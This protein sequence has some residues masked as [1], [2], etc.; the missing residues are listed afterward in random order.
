MTNLIEIGQSSVP[1]VNNWITDHLTIDIP[2]D[3]RDNSW[4]FNDL[5]WWESFV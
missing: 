4:I 5:N 1:V 3:H 2:F